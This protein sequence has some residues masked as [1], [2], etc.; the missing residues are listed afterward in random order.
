M[1]KILLTSWIPNRR[2]F[3]PRKAKLGIKFIC[4]MAQQQED[5][6]R[7]IFD[8]SC[9]EEFTL[10]NSDLDGTGFT[11]LTDKQCIEHTHHGLT[12]G[13]HPFSIELLLTIH[14]TSPEWRQLPTDMESETIP[15]ITFNKPMLN[16]RCSDPISQEV[17]YEVTFEGTE[18]D[19]SL[20]LP[21]EL[22]NEICLT[23]KDSKRVRVNWKPAGGIETYIDEAFVVSTGDF[24]AKSQFGT[25]L[26]PVMSFLA[27][28]QENQ[29]YSRSWH[30]LLKFESVEMVL[31]QIER[32][33]TGLKENRFN[34]PPGHL[35]QQAQKLV[36]YLGPYVVTFLKPLTTSVETEIEDI[37]IAKSVI[38]RFEILRHAIGNRENLVPYLRAVLRTNW[39][40]VIGHLILRN[41]EFYTQF[42]TETETVHSADWKRVKE[43]EVFVTGHT[44]CWIK[45]IVQV[46]LGSRM[47]R[48]FLQSLSQPFTSRKVQSHFTYKRESWQ[49]IQHYGFSQ[50]GNEIIFVDSHD[51]EHEEYNVSR[52]MYNFSIL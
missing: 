47:T 48:T 45:G 10:V 15:R 39:P 13:D 26:E 41:R 50:Q 8:T 38:G 44:P 21:R 27:N 5:H 2:A 34:L 30:K 51:P 6:K 46:V 43:A 28:P 42:L 36:S 9:A 31:N 37:N 23:L 40:R 4:D 12:A 18:F 3:S 14:G 1:E 17:L 11:C 24:Q 49:Q 33:L 32:N 25:L 52:N 22:Q 29:L 19:R 20:N 16:F 7:T 35:E